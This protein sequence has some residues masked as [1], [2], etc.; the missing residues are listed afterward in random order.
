MVKNE[1]F[2]ADAPSAMSDYPDLIGDTAVILAKEKIVPDVV[3][4]CTD[5]AAF[6]VMYGGNMVM[7]GDTLS[8][9]D[10][11][12]EPRI[13]ITQCK[14]TGVYSLLMLDPDMPSPHKPEYKDVLIWMVN[15]IKKSD[16]ETG[17]FTVEYSGPEPGK[18]Q[19]RYAVLLF[20]QPGFQEIEPPAK[21]AYFQT[22]QW[23]KDHSWGD[24]V[25]GVYFKVK[26]GE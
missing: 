9:D 26:H 16:F 20:E 22:K 18:G 15:N 3:D 17:D 21:R 5:A 14:P 13:E 25:A 1:G 19:H 6:K 23:A 4:N 10:V 8:I 7:P 11:A 24:P 2:R 12:Q